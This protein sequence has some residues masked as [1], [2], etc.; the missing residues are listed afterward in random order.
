MDWISA[1][2][3]AIVVLLLVWRMSSRKPA[4]FPPGPRGLPLLGYTPFIMKNPHLVLRD[5]GQ[6]YGSVFSLPLF[7]RHAI[8]L[9]DWKAVKEAL[10]HQSSIF[11]GRP[12]TVVSEVLLK[13]S[14]LAFATSNGW[15]ERRRFT[16]HHLKNF[17]FGKRSMEAVIME[18]VNQLLAHLRT[19]DSQKYTID[20]IIF[21]SLLNIIWTI[22]GGKRFTYGDEYMKE[23]IEALDSIFE[24]LAPTNLCNFLLWLRHIPGSGFKKFRTEFNK[25]M[26]FLS[27]EV[28]EHINAYQEGRVRDFIDVYLAEIY[29]CGAQKDPSGPRSFQKEHLVGVIWNLY[30]AGI[31]TGNSTLSWALLYMITWPE[32]QKKLQ[33]ELDD[34][35]GR[36]RL[37]AYDDRSRLPYTEA[38]ILEIQRC[39]TVAPLSIAHKTTATTELF[40]YTIPK[41]TVVL[42]NI[43]AVH[44]DP[45]L[46][47]DPEVFRP[48][49][50]LDASGRVQKPEYLIPFSVGGRVCPGESLARVELFLFLSCILHQFSLSM[51]DS[52]KPPSFE[53]SVRIVLK[54]KPFPVIIKQR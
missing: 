48:E 9:H 8:V 45:E 15:K 18:E 4:G 29:H 53:A 27:K 19:M 32:V 34:V 38:T 16:L 39:A 7:T 30:L 1:T 26:S 13:N 49:R 10:V 35:V 42:E 28:D 37:P 41:S 24:G 23:F 40:G 50:F 36:E 3:L 12:P 5:L 47:G 14:D 46:W 2:L 51:A 6:K 44:H 25:L 22:V 52:E 31:D 33:Q 54:P 43:W 11:S 20:N 21:F 17:G